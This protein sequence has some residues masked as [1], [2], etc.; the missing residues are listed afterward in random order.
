MSNV[1]LLLK[2][3][4]LRV[5][6]IQPAPLLTFTVV[7]DANASR[8]IARYYTDTRNGL[9][10]DYLTYQSGA[11]KE[12]RYAIILFSRYWD[13][14][15]SS[16]NNDLVLDETSVSN[17]LPYPGSTRH[18]FEGDVPA[19]SIDLTTQTGSVA[20][21]EAIFPIMS[22]AKER[23]NGSL[24][25]Y[26]LSGRS[27]SHSYIGPV[28]Y[29][30]VYTYSG[31]DMRYP[32][33]P[34]VSLRN[35]T[36]VSSATLNV[37]ELEVIDF[38]GDQVIGSTTTEMTVKR[39]RRMVLALLHQFLHFRAAKLT[40]SI[41][42]GLTGS[43]PR[44]D[45]RPFGK[46]IMT[47]SLDL[48]VGEVVNVDVE[49]YGTKKGLVGWNGTLVAFANP[50]ELFICPANDQTD[51]DIA[52][53]FWYTRFKPLHP[54]IA[55]YVLRVP[56]FNLY[57]LA[58]KVADSE[59]TK[60]PIIG[61]YPRHFGYRSAQ[62]SVTRKVGPYVNINPVD[63]REP[64]F[65]KRTIID[66]TGGKSGDV[67]LDTLDWLSVFGL[68]AFTSA[69]TTWLLSKGITS[70]TSTSDSTSLFS[71]LSK[72]LDELGEKLSNIDIPVYFG[73]RN[74]GRRTR[75]R[76]KSRTSRAKK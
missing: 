54:T 47:G 14:F 60:F 67:D 28:I 17:D 10:A 8:T 39:K 51:L 49:A 73:E 75:R 32:N 15:S 72:R 42:T 58:S 16:V 62:R 45:L 50:D 3:S 65:S 34:A 4:G 26:S 12:L 35:Y 6:A 46:F 40:S 19:D 23:R 22:V 68:S 20:I 33:L 76:P 18:L 25:Q 5:A 66:K 52:L 2:L 38:L 41:T 36:A 37:L 44:H 48:K 11:S 55:E 27:I 24:Y 29:D 64:F 30:A 71:A 63:V 13:R 53:P 70:D 59:T 61:T 69:L 74:E 1:N 7:P 56:Q 9:T 43:T 21:G 57:I 31:L